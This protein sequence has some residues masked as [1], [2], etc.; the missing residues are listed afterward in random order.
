M[1]YIILIS[2]T[3]LISVKSIA[4]KE[5]SKL[6]I[7]ADHYRPINPF[8]PVNATQNGFHFPNNFGFAFGVERDWNSKK[9]SRAYQTL[10]L[11]YYNEV[12]FER[13]ATVETNF[14]MG[15]KV[16]Q[17]LQAGFEAGVGYQRATSSNLASFYEEGKWVSKVDNSIKTNRITPG[18]SV[19]LGYDFSQ[20]FN[21]K[22]PLTLSISS[23]GNALLPY[24]P[25]AFLPLG[26]MRNNRISLKYRI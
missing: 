17:G 8:S 21:G 9:R 12:Y 6:Q 7:R 22:L 25:E 16:F 18:L 1:R 26:L 2:L 15:F 3:I 11:G 19:N 23:G 4:Q 13:V 10:M 14:G 5:Q 20:H 24:V